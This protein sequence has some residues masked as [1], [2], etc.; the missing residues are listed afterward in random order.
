MI[1]HQTN[2]SNNQFSKT[3]DTG[4]HNELVHFCL[5]KYDTVNWD[6]A[7]LNLL[8]CKCCKISYFWLQK[9]IFWQFLR[10]KEDKD[11]SLPINLTSEIFCLET[12]VVRFLTSDT[13]LNFFVRLILPWKFG[14]GS[15]PQK[16]WCF[17]ECKWLS[18]IWSVGYYNSI[19]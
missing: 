3:P 11:E 7:L 13:H 4:D 19:P 1:Y 8:R 17:C 15:Q 2:A 18:K 10:N 12:F 9:W 14:L 16:V 6:S 5:K